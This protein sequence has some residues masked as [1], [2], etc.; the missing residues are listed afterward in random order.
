MQAAAAVAHGGLAA[1]ATD[2]GLG[3]AA[4]RGQE[5]A[6]AVTAVEA[7]AAIGRK[8]GCGTDRARGV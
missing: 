7:A 8:T 4:G 1:A 2:P 5:V 3:A 6:G